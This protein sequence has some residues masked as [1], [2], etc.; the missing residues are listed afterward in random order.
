MVGAHPTS[1]AVVMNWLA[2]VPFF[3]PDQLVEMT[4]VLIVLG[5]ALALTLFGAALVALR[6][7]DV[8]AERNDR[9][10]AERRSSTC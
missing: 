8:N 6:T 3:I 4:W 10:S 2:T 7:I 5:T 1:D 9:R